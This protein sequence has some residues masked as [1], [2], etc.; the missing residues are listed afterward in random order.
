MY[1]LIHPRIRYLKKENGLYEFQGFKRRWIF[2]LKRTW[3]TLSIM[4]DYE[5]GELIAMFELGM[6]C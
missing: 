4:P 3:V 6:V 5:F 1:I 2:S